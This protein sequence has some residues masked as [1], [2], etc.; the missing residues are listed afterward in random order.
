M[1]DSEDMLNAPTYASRLNRHQQNSALRVLRDTSQG[2]VFLFFRCRSVDWE[3]LRTVR[4]TKGRRP[5]D[6]VINLAFGQQSVKQA[7]SA[8]EPALKDEELTT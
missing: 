8:S 2:C 6:L 4:V 1:F 5:T 3:R 7:D